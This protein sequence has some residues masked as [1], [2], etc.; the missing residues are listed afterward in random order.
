MSPPTS[1]LLVVAIA[2]EVCG[3][4]ALR[5]SEGLTHPWAVVAVVCGYGGS[6]AVMGRVLTRGMALG[7]AYGTLTAAGLVA[8]TLLSV[9]A[10]GDDL[11]LV[12]LAGIL[13]LGAGAVLLQT[14][15]P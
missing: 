10:F 1:L 9:V 2:G 15:R 12:Q 4:A 8:A 3:T 11:S 6:I 14:G 7:V 13:V 5:L